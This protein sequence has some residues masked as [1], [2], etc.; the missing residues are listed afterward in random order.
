[1]ADSSPTPRRQTS[2]ATHQR[3]LPYGRQQISEDDIEAVAAALRAPIITQG[4]RVAELEA[5]FCDYTGAG[6]AIAFS[7]GTAALHGAAYAAGLGPGSVGLVPTITFAASA[8]CL[9]Y[10]GAQPHFVDIEPDSLNIDPR[11]VRR[12]ANDHA[13]VEA[14]V[15][16]S[17]AG[18]PV[19]LAP[20]RDAG[21]TIIEDGCHALGGHRGGRKIGGPGGADMT[22]F[23][24]HPVKALTTGEG[25]VLTTED[26]ELA[27]RARRFRE[28]GIERKPINADGPWAYDVVE[29]GY[30]YRLTD[31]QCALGLSQL[32]RLDGWIAERNAIAAG[33][34]ELLGDDDRLVLPPAAPS[35]SLHAYHLFAIQIRGGSAERLRVF[36][37]LREAGIGVQV[38]YVPLDH[39]THFQDCPAEATPNAE[40]YYAGAISLPVFPGLTRSELERV[41]AELSRL[42]DER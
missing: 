36:Q 2:D 27:T 34:R 14:V 26:P 15:A 22:A 6:H 5:A 33:Y 7:S 8:N 35:G 16:V 18:L 12:V 1:M 17:F 29:P 28:H 42:L 13:E 39:F 41:V 37:G 25:G 21:L 3:F 32:S 10:V 38:H 19:D 11:A 20:L 23:S 24:L 9:R 30:N 31:F 4:P 40:H